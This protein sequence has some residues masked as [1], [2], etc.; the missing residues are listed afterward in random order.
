MTTEYKNLLKKLNKID[1]KDV[2]S[3]MIMVET[4]KVSEDKKTSDGVN[5]AEGE[6]G[7]LLNLICNIDK[8]L[9][10]AWFISKLSE[11]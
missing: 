2:V 1:E 4:N 8:P 7:R 10:I 9:M 3:Y 5:A 6:P 11:D